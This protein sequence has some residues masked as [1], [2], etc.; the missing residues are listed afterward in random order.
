MTTQEL[1]EL[2]KEASL[3]WRY[4]DSIKNNSIKDNKG[5]SKVIFINYINKELFVEFCAC[6][7]NKISGEK[8][9]ILCNVTYKLI[10]DIYNRNEE[11]FL[12][13]SI[14]NIG[15]IINNSSIYIEYNSNTDCNGRYLVTVKY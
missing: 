2:N 4:K 1:L 6:D 8:T 11:G 12:Q 9:S 10:E 5:L 14:Y 7:I 3:L 15:D 13:N